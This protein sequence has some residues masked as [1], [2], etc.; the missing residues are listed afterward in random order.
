MRLK[1]CGGIT[2][3]V[4]FSFCFFS[5]IEWTQ[6]LHFPWCIIIYFVSWLILAQRNMSI[7]DITTEIRRGKNGQRDFVVNAEVITT[8]KMDED[9]LWVDV[10][11]RCNYLIFVRIRSLM[12]YFCFLL[13]LT[14]TSVI[15]NDCSNS[16]LAEVRYS[17]YLYWIGGM[18]DLNRTSF[19]CFSFLEFAENS[20]SKPSRVN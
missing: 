2:P 3:Y 15:D 16:F 8:E 5:S 12:Q 17:Q 13:L 1:K 7:E 14:S 4:N 10:W 18:S 11:C 6:H 19:E 9:H 20:S